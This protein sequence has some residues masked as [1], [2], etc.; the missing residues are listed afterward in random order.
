MERSK[1]EVAG[2]FSVWK[3]RC[4]SGSFKVTFEG[5]TGSEVVPLN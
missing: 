3:V 1:E 5:G 2:D 4:N